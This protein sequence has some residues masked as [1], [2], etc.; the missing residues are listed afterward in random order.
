MIC[1]SEWG[2]ARDLAVSALV[3][4]PSGKGLFDGYDHKLDFH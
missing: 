1:C 2:G 3:Q 4:D